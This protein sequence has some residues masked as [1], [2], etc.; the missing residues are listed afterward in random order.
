MQEYL[1][2]VPAEIQKA[3][4][5]LIAPYTGISS[6]EELMHS[7]NKEE[8]PVLDQHSAESYTKL[9]YWSLKRA[10]EAGKLKTLPGGGRKR[11]YRQSDLDSFLKGE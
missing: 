3:V 2:K 11:L 5:G 8:D 7:L 6:I 4:M 9:S 1:K 10:E